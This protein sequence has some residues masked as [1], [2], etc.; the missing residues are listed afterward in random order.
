M[1][2]QKH[3]K[4]WAFILPGLLAGTVILG[5][6]IV[7]AFWNSLHQLRLYRMDQQMFIGLANYARLWQDPIFLL[8]ARVTIVFTVGCTVLSVVAALAIAAVMSTRGIR[9]TTMAR[10]YMAFFL[11]P[12]VATQV[13]VGVIGRLFV[14]EPE[15]GFVNFLL[16]LFGVDG[17]GWLISTDTALIAT[18]I[19][20]AW[21]LTPLALLIFY[22]ALATVPSELLESAEVDGAG[23]VVAFL[24]V[25]LPLIRYHI[26]FVTLILLTSAFREFDMVYSLTG[27]GPGRATNV[28]SLHVYNQGISSANMGVANAIAFSMLLLVSVLSVIYIRVAKLGD[29]SGP[30]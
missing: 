29:L 11:I 22:A 12:F 16:A 5:I 1:S 8:S 17:P 2:S 6:P 10:F 21:R 13:I 19:T 26:G 30:E 18:I 15:Y 27:G 20:N 25:K 28:L 7:Q 23:G 9:G 4:P 14:W 24:R 3:F